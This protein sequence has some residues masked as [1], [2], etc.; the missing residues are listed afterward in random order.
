MP[1]GREGPWAR[2]TLPPR[3]AHSGAA[4]SSPVSQVRRGEQG[5]NGLVQAHWLV[6]W[7]DG[8]VSETPSLRMALS[9]FRSRPN[10]V[11]G[12]PGGEIGWGQGR[13]RGC[14]SAIS[15]PP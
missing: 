10:V 6:P 3:V 9:S 13:V 8:P 11:L 4:L 7:V 2:D 1:G 14:G 5:Q 15:C 12:H